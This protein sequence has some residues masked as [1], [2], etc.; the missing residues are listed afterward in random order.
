VESYNEQKNNDY[1][2]S[3]PYKSKVLL[4]LCKNE[5]MGIKEIFQLQVH[6]FLFLVSFTKVLSEYLNLNLYKQMKIE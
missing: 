6:S 1:E 5:K 3:F 4:D 2:N